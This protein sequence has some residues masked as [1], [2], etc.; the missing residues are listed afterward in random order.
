[1]PTP[2]RS[3][4]RGKNIDFGRLLGDQRSLSLGE[5]NHAGH[6]L[7]PAGKCSEKAEQHEGFVKRRLLRIGARQGR[8]ATR[9]F[10]AQHMIVG[11][12]VAVAQILR[13][14]RPIANDQ[15]IATD[16]EV[17][18]HGP[19]LHVHSPPV[20][21][22]RSV[23]SKAAFRQRRCGFNSPLKAAPVELELAP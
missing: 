2:R 1:M 7:D 10:G 19:Y 23:G 8:L 4:T 6:E 22:A 14:L 5:N 18:E 12:N 11:Q 21:A 9:V 15:R 16:L 20:K 13:G 17:W 3:L